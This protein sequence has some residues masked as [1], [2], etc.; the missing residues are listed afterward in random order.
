MDEVKVPQEIMVGLFRVMCGVSYNQ[1]GA[2]VDKSAIPNMEES[3]K[4]IIDWGKS[5]NIDSRGYPTKG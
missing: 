3:I 5:N 4:W 2:E 1:S